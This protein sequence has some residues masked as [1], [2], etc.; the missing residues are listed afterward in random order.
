MTQSFTPKKIF[1]YSPSTLNTPSSQPSQHP[2]STCSLLRS[3]VTRAPDTV[4]QSA[5]IKPVR[6][7][8]GLF[9]FV[10]FENFLVLYSWC[11]V[12]HGRRLSR[13]EA[14]GREIN[15]RSLKFWPDSRSD[16]SPGSQI[17]NLGATQDVDNRGGKFC[18]RSSHTGLLR[19][20]HR[21]QF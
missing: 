16:D 13:E 12:R 3:I 15:H 21:V 6:I 17:K 9:L 8:H 20:Q 14:R 2:P 18:H 7:E 19:L 10:P 4:I 11:G 5:Q 1:K